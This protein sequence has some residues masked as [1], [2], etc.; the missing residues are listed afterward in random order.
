MNIEETAEWAGRDLTPN[1]VKLFDFL[2]PVARQRQ[3]DRILIAY[4]FLECDVALLDAPI[5]QVALNGVYGM[6]SDGS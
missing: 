6:N 2:R 4:A 3:K 1:E 5:P